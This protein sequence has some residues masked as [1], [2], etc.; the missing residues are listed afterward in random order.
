MTGDEI[1][2][3]GG[4][5]RMPAYVTG[6]GEP[7]RPEAV[8]WLS[9]EE[10]V[11]GM[12]PMRPGEGLD[13][14]CASLA[15]VCERPLVGEPRSPTRLRVASS[16]VAD[17]LRRGFPDL[18][19]HVAP[20]PEIDE[21][22]DSLREWMDREEHGAQSYLDA[23]I[24]PEAVGA[25]F[26]AAAA[27]YRMRPWNIV[28][29]D[30]TLFAVTIETLNINEA[31]A[32]VIGQAGE[33][34]GII[35]FR[36]LDHYDDYVAA[37]YAFDGTAPPP[38]PAHLALNFERGADVDPALRKEIAAHGWEVAARDAYPSPMAVDEDLTTRPL[39]ARDFAILEAV[40]L[41]LSRTLADPEPL[42]VAWKSGES[43][44]RKERVALHSGD[45]DVELITPYGV[46]DPEQDRLSRETGELVAAF[47][48]SPEAQRLDYPE[49]CELVLH[50]AADRF[51]TGIEGLGS[52]E[53][54]TCVFEFIPRAALVGVE[55]ARPIVEAT[56]ALYRWL[57]RER[58]LEQAD[59]CLKV[60]G[61]SAIRRL[62]QKLADEAN[63]GPTKAVLM[64]G[65]EAGVDVDSPEE[66]ERWLDSLLEPA[67]DRAPRSQANPNAR[68]K[69]RKAAR[70]ARKG[71]RKR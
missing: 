70:K 22:V 57:R 64:A 23:D 60:L 45:A 37:A 18:V 21:V 49:A 44:T 32:L 65:R 33:S 25:C 24:A 36:D 4:I 54:R 71:N 34:F 41:A 39:V 52:R 8:V 67:P 40:S 9:E 69:Q 68:K 12:T 38:V 31:V 29:D 50:L 66:V 15:E 17:V 13:A 63:F 20:T 2:W 10:L 56:R 11:L 48:D 46:E 62:E 6:E 3:L 16:A 30:E 28:P 58:G 35:V 55:D 5:I 7:Y 51:G 47:S 53:L 1:E 27:L 43:V 59:A 14:V 26:R 42:R 19:V 61:G